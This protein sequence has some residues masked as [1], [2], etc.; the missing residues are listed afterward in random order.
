MP[1]RS[2]RVHVGESREEVQLL[3]DGTGPWRAAARGARRVARRLDAAG[4]RPG[5]IPRATSGCIDRRT[6]VVH[7]VQLTDARARPARGHRRHAG[8]LPAQQPLGRRRRRR[9]SRAFYASGVRVAVGTDS[10]ASVAD[11]NLFAELAAMR[12]ARAGG[13][14]APPAAQPRRWPAPRRCGST[15]SSGS[16]QP[17]RLRHLVAV[18]RAAR[19]SPIRKRRWSA[20]SPPDRIQV[21][22]A[23][24]RR[25]RRCLMASLGTY[26]SFVRIS[27]TVFA[28]PFALT[29]ALLAACGRPLDWA[30]LGWIL[31]VHGRRRAAPR[32]ASTG[33]STP[34]FDAAQPAHRRPR[35]A[36]RRDDQRA[37]RRCSSSCGP[38]VFVAAAFQISALCGWLSPVALA[39]VFWYSLAKRYTH[40]TQAFL[41]LAMAVAPVGGWLAAG[42]RGGWTPWL[43]GLA[44]GLWVAGFDIIYA[45]QDVGC[46]SRA[47]AEVDPG[48]L[49]HR[50]RA[51]DLARAAR[52]DGGWSWPAWRWSRRSAP[53]YLAGVARRGARCSPTSSRSSR[54]SDLSRRGQG[55]RSQRLRRHPLPGRPRRSRC[56]S[57]DADSGAPR[58]SRSTRRRRASPGCSTR[59]PPATTCSTCVLSAGLD[60]LWRRQ[61]IRSLE[62]TGAERLLDVCTGTAD[63]AIGA[64]RVVPRR[65]AGRRRGLRR[66][67]AA[68]RSRQDRRRPGCRR[69]SS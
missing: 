62:L 55:L 12:A 47:G 30:A 33:W 34:R 43:L 8:D 23:R 67:D 24:G 17:G 44:I 50:P 35:A 69:G 27:H 31:V 15:T 19:S 6:L 48:A 56:M 21:A 22:A 3:R 7:G 49:R 1:R 51:D 39:I 38:V 61:A 4:S 68:A 18:A 16:L 45:C 63:V 2:R 26:L 37:R 59:S 36:A 9:R 54:P 60:R 46:R 64:A 65:Q 29:G 53:V 10:L 52:G 13:A 41:G 28:L 25:A 57:T 14:G 32:W 11:L 58:P 20:V 66:R 42:G 40:Y 5:A